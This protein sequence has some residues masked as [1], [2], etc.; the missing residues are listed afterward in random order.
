MGCDVCVDTANCSGTC[1]ECMSDKVRRLTMANKQL[2]KMCDQYLAELAAERQRA[3]LPG[4]LVDRLKTSIEYDLYKTR[5]TQSA[6][7]ALLRDILTAVEQ[8][9][10]YLHAVEW[11]AKKVGE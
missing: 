7:G 8:G 11:M 2:T 10:M 9:D 1:S 4:E 3:R 6:T 5:A